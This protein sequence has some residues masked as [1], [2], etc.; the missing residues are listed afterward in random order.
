VFGRFA[1]I[2]KPVF[3]KFDREAMK[4]AFVKACNKTFDNLP[5]NKF[6]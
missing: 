2:V 5:G 3:G 6:Q 4:R 1:G